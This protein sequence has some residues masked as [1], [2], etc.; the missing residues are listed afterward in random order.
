VRAI[1]TAALLLVGTASVASQECNPD[2]AGSCVPDVWPADVDCAGGSGDGP[3]C[4]DGTQSVEVVDTDRY[5]LDTNDRDTVVCEP[6]TR[7]MSFAS[8]R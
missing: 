7:L 3:S 8:S 2:Y 6:P 5:C 4:A 1:S